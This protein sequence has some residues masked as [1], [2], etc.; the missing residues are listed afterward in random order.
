MKVGTWLSGSQH[1]PAPC[2]LAVL[3]SCCCNKH[4]TKASSGRKGLFW[5]TQV[6]SVVHRGAGVGEHGSR[7]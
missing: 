6:V 5:L 3:V 1:I 2:L 7:E 4:L